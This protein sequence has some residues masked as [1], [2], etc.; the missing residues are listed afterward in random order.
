MKLAFTSSDGIIIDMVLSK[1]EK[2]YIYE[3][4]RGA[5]FY[6]G[7][8][9]LELNGLQNIEDNVKL[10]KIY[11]TIKDCQLLFTASIDDYPLH[12][13]QEKGLHVE[14]SRGTINSTFLKL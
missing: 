2:F 6:R 14:V 3:M 4:K 5:F 8:R 7:E 13:L 10:Q 11:K 9:K 1:V 12:Y